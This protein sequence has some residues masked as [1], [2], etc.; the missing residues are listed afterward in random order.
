[1]NYH[2]V[3]V[4]PTED[5]ANHL[6]VLCLLQPALKKKGFF[7]PMP[8]HS[9]RSSELPIPLMEPTAVETCCRLEPEPVFFGDF[10]PAIPLPF[11]QM[12]VGAKDEDFVRQNWRYSRRNKIR[13][14]GQPEREGCS[15]RV[16]RKALMIPSGF[17]LT[18]IVWLNG[19]VAA[20]V[21][22]YNNSLI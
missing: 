15:L 1:M 9:F 14:F 20:F 5:G 4:K 2:D 13:G 22:E 18:W 17:K 11:F 12:L 16:A 8:K 3:A 6:E 7:L 19:E 10:T 21:D